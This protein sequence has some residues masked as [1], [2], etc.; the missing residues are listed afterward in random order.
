[1]KLTVYPS[2]LEGSVRVPSS[3]SHLHRLLIAS[4]L[5]EKPTDLSYSG[6][7]EDIE[8]TARCLEALGA[9]IRRT[10]GSCTVTPVNRHENSLLD[11]G[12][13]GSTLRFLLPVAA[14]LGLQSR[15]TGSGRLPQRPIAPLVKALNA[16][17]AEIIGETLPLELRG[18]LRGGRYEIPGNIS[19]QF[20]SGLLFALPLCGED[21]EIVLTSPLASAAYADMTAACLR[22]F[23]IEIHAT[24]EG[25]SVRGE[26]RYLSPTSISAEGDWS[27][28]AFWLA[29]NF[30]GSRVRA[31]G[32]SFDSKQPDRAAEELFSRVGGTVD[33]GGCPDLLP[34][35][36][37]CAGRREV[38]TRVTGGARLRLKES[39]R[40]ASAAAMLNALG[41]HAVETEDG[42]LIEGVR[43]YRSCEVN[44]FSDHRV[45]MA[46]AVAALGADGPVT[47]SDCESVSKS[48]PA[49]FDDFERL[50][51]KI[52][53]K[54][55]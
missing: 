43:S 44:G 12:E 11:C 50:G 20:V 16:H 3:K 48:Y 47:I 18:R 6:A 28:A 2:R 21:S 29:A 5:S 31:E 55:D 7:G 25:Y 22:T 41:A 26:Q 17:G 4:A 38:V 19:S 51:G 1:M 37:V 40:L 32:L 24:K 14:A 46:A 36:A 30:L 15:F 8:A 52:R 53:R 35:F 33:I 13:S 45:V 34:V 49:F 54:E 42:L 39:D 9:V 27:A 10:D 23:G